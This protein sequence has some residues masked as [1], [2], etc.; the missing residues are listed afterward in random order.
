[1][2]KLILIADSE[3]FAGTYYGEYLELNTNYLATAYEKL[4]FPKI[5]SV[6]VWQYPTARVRKFQLA[7]NTNNVPYWDKGELI[8]KPIIGNFAKTY[9]ISDRNL[10]I[11]NTAADNDFVTI[12]CVIDNRPVTIKAQYNSKTNTICTSRFSYNG[13]DIIHFSRCDITKSLYMSILKRAAQ[14]LNLKIS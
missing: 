3:P 8:S 7:N 5:Q 14:K 2:Y 6:F 1:M 4:N 13:R 10:K 9:I 12:E 11:I